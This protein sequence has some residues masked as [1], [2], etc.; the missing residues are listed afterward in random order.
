MIRF[1]L[2]CL[3]GAAG[4]GARYLLGGWVQR[5]LAVSFPFGTITVN[6]IGSFLISIL[7]YLGLEKQVIS[8]DLRVVLV[9]GVLGGFTTY[10]SFNYETL[11][12]FQDGALGLA[13]LNVGATVVACLAAGGMGLVLARVAAG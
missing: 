9:T 3:G 11:R 8:P 10:S 5:T 13:V 2:V 1:L 12:L 6:V 4:S 7:M